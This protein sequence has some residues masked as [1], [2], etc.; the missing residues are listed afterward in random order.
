MLA[1]QAPRRVQRDSERHRPAQCRDD[2]RD[3][4]IETSAVAALLK[5]R[6]G[7]YVDSPLRR[8][9]LSADATRKRW[10]RAAAELRT[11]LE[12]PA[13]SDLTGAPVGAG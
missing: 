2:R 4:S 1:G 3:V 5:D 7:E 11:R 6:L 12:D 10:E 9:G 8:L 13:D